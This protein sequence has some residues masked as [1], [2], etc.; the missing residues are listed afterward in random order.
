VST[1][2]HERPTGK[3]AGSALSAGG[4]RPETPTGRPEA[5]RRLAL[6]SRRCGPTGPELPERDLP[7]LGRLPR[8]GEEVEHRLLP[9][10]PAT[11]AVAAL[12]LVC[13]VVVA[14]TAGAP[15][16]AAYSL[17]V[18]PLVAMLTGPFVGADTDWRRWRKNRHLL[19]VC[20]PCQPLSMS[21]D[22]AYVVPRGE[23]R[24]RT[25][26]P[27]GKGSTVSPFPPTSPQAPP[28]QR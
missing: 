28:Q 11:V 5:A 12:I 3:G 15:G 2:F 25:G 1:L 10:W 22:A 6:P 9:P 19:L 18:R 24:R 27:G 13:A 8:Q 21:F 26:D 7:L 16:L 14:V 23:V 4:E 17:L 20:P